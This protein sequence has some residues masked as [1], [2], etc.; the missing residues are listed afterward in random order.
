MISLCVQRLRAV[1]NGYEVS[2]TTWFRILCPLLLVVV[3]TGF[4][5]AL[6]AFAQNE[7]QPLSEAVNPFAKRVDAVATIDG[8][9]DWVTS[10]AWSPDGESLATGTYEFVKIWNAE[11]KQIEAELKVPSGFGRSLAY[12]PDG[13]LLAAGHYQGIVIWRTSDKKELKQIKGPR[14]YVTSLAFSPDGSRLA[15]SS[16][17]ERVTVWNVSD[18]E[19]VLQLEGHSYPVQGVAYSPDGKLLASA[20]GDEDRITRRGELKIWN[21]ESGAELHAFEDH[22]KAATSVAFS[23]DGEYLVSTSQDET[24]NVYALAKGKAVGFFGGHSRPTTCAV[25]GPDSRVVCSGSGGRAKGKNEVILWNCETGETLATI[26]SHT[27][28]VTSVALAPSGKQLATAG[29]DRTVAIWN[30]GQWLLPAESPEEDADSAR[31]TQNVVAARTAEPDDETGESSPQSLRAGIIGLDTSHVIHFTRLLNSP[32]VRPELAGCR[33]VAAYP[34]GS[35]D[36]KSSVERVPKYTEQVQEFGVEIVQSIDELIERVDVVLLETNDGRPHLE[37]VIPVLQAGK[38]VFI[39]KPIAGS[40]ADAVA[41]FDLAEKYDVPVF[42]S[43]SLRYTTGALEARD[44][45]AGP[46]TGCETYSPCALEKTHPDLYWYGIHG[47]ELLYAVMGTGCQTV[48]RTSTESTDVVVGLWD[49]GRIGTFRGRRSGGGYGGIIFTEK[50]P[51]PIGKYQGYE[52][53]LVEIVQ[54]FRSRT[55]PVDPAETL[56]IYTFMEAADESK[57]QGGSPVSLSSVLEAARAE[58]KQ[59]LETLSLQPAVQ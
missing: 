11:Q 52:P 19:L 29:Y 1:F 57:R 5:N 12:S 3:L 49:G 16:E 8:Y 45:A 59:K 4:G 15:A 41:I 46:V 47:V 10:L 54:F 56:E 38:P 14:G 7:L 6:D 32:E 25:F 24:I 20:A 58:A 40:L 27:S 34:R 9:S 42:S 48:A 30:V 51:L 44:G 31:S 26:D 2:T 23:P 22:Q 35:P 53:L 50:K 17:D 36:I 21:A 28:K 55:A 43:S 13:T 39:D 33:V 37:Q 18:G